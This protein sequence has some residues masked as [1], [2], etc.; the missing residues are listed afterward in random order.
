VARGGIWEGVGD[1]CSPS[2]GGLWVW[3]REFAE[4]AIANYEIAIFSLNSPGEGNKVCPPITEH[5]GAMLGKHRD[6]GNPLG[7]INGGEAERDKRYR[8]D[9]F[10]KE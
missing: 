2:P 4:S 1:D 5:K 10:G 8:S 9:S 7:Q 6:K 3:G